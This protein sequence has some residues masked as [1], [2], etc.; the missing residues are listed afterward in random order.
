VSAFGPTKRNDFAVPRYH[1]RIQ[2]GEFSGAPDLGT[3]FAD[4]NAAW[5]EL[6]KVSG[7]LL[8][9]V[10]RKLKQNA[11]WRIELLDDARKPVFRVSLTAETLDR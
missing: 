11:S 7:D 3:E 9:S 8:G 2:Q 6:A 1:F 5:A 10:A 4:D